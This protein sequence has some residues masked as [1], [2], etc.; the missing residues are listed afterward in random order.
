MAKPNG[1]KT[2]PGVASKASEALK[3]GKTSPTTKSIAGSA[4]SNAKS[5][6]KK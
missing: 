2:G 6:T 4:L 1:V 5:T 3:S